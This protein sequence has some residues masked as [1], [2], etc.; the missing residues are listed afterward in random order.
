MGGDGGRLLRSRERSHSASARG[1]LRRR[2]GRRRRGPSARSPRRSRSGRGGGRRS[3]ARPPAPASPPARRRGSRAG[4]P[5]GSGSVSG[6]PST[7]GRPSASASAVSSAASGPGPVRRPPR[8]RPGRAR[9]PRSPAVSSTARSSRSA[10]ARRRASSP[11][12]A[13]GPGRVSSATRASTCSVSPGPS[14]HVPARRAVA[15]ARATPARVEA[16][17]ERL[18]QVRAREAVR[19]ALLAQRLHELADRLPLHALGPGEP[20]LAPEVDQHLVAPRGHALEELVE[21]LRRVELVEPHPRLQREHELERVAGIDR[22]IGRDL[23]ASGRVRPGGH[24]Y[25]G[26]HL[27]SHFGLV[28][29]GVALEHGVAVAL[30]VQQFDVRAGQRRPRQAGEHVGVRRRDL[31]EA[32]HAELAHERVLGVDPAHRRG[33]LARQQ[34]DARRR[35]RVNGRPSRFGTQRPTSGSGSIVQRVEMAAQLLDGAAQDRRVERDVDAR[36]HPHR[37]ACRGAPRAR[38]S[39]PRSRRPRTGGRSRCG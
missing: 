14:P 33:E 15:S 36:Q 37:A 30:G 29:R 23:G 34:V 27:R 32:A 17:R 12:R 38:R 9:S 26:G 16:R 7:A 21:R 19:R 24:R 31:D 6:S 4:P 3:G 39:R 5:S 35:R 2:R 28:G 13:D 11:P 22:A 8:A 25:R 10:P 20:E 18:A 1:G